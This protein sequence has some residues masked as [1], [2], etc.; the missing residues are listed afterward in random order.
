MASGQVAVNNVLVTGCADARGY[1]VQVKETD[2]GYQGPDNS[3]IFIY[4]PAVV[5]TGA[6]PTLK[7][8]DRVSLNPAT[9][10]VFF[11]QVQLTNAT[12]TVEA[13]MDEAPP[14]PIAVTAAQA[15]GDQPTALE[16]VLVTVSNVIVTQV[17][18]PA[19]PGDQAPT[20]EFGVDGSLRVNDLMYLAAP[21]PA[22]NAEF[23]S[24]TGVL[25][26]R[27]GNSKLEPRDA[28]DLVAGAP[29]IVDF[30]P[31]LSFVRQGDS[32]V[33][34]IP[35]PLTVTLSGP[36]QGDT[37]VAIASADPTSLTVVGGGVTIANGQTSAPVLVDGLLQA[38]SVGLTASLDTVMVNADVR[39]VGAAEVPQLIAIDPPNSVVAPSASVPIKVV[40]DIPSN[41]TNAAVT[42]GLLPGTFGTVPAMVSV[43]ADQTSASFMFMAGAN[44]GTETLT[45]T[46][47]GSMAQASIDVAVNGGLVINEVDYDQPG[48]DSDE[49]VEI[50]NSTSVPI[51]LATIELGL[52][53]GNNNSSYTCV[54]LAAAGMLGPGEFLVVG[55][56][57]LL[58]TVPAGVST[59][60][61]AGASN[62]VQNGAP[63]GLLLIDTATATI[64][65]SLSYEGA[66]TNASA[67][68]A[69]MLNLVEGTVLPVGVADNNATP[70]SLIRL[71]DGS[72][73]D[74][75]AADW[76]LS[77][78]PTPGAANM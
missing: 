41:G 44:V 1:F 54:P 10:N 42:L 2:V 35:A 45:A 36:A 55:S 64:V 19:G 39:V 65:D 14:A 69:S 16:S 63:D 34:T 72:D 25:D 68:G 74:D 53:N 33:P 46:L 13:S 8:G 18:P 66:I 23:A 61:F 15:G 11:S 20:N 52:V 9:V 30:S 48:A 38:A 62:N 56:N 7:R 29:I 3:G 32:G 57:T 77:A 76:S 58:A 31:G 71:P 37:F 43:P 21:L 40:L 6:T 70:A 59:I 67:C 60:A 5:C 51:S 12:I 27:N 73:S 47:G 4:D 28:L 26:Y 75:A 17:E 78:T 50:Y 22:V 24:I 49:F